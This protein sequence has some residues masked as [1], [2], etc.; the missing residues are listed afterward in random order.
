MKDWLIQLFAGL[1]H[2]IATA[3]I[4]MVPITEM[5]AA[6][7][8]AINVYELSI[9]VAIISA[10]LGNIVP[11]FFVFAFFPRIR[12]LIEKRIPSLNAWV[13]KRYHSKSE[14]FRK[15]YQR[16]GALALFL[17]VAIPTPFSGVWSG[18]VLAIVFHIPFKYAGPALFV[19]LFITAI[20]VTLVV[21]G[22]LGFLSWMI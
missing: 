1:P 2:E 9:P 18:S 10:Y 8:I 5:Q 14:S 15:T 3:L 20:I 19:G 13:Q 7:P 12:E 17:Y 11:I 21:Q 6:I 16:Y 4:A 22:V